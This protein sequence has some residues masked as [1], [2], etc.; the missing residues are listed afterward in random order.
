MLTE[1]VKKAGGT[2]E[3]ASHWNGCDLSTNKG[4]SRLLS[5]IDELYVLEHTP[6]FYSDAPAMP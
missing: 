4:L 1:E 3:R 2:A 5:K 6:I